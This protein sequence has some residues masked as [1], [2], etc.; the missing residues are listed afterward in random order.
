MTITLKMHRAT[1][2]L[3]KITIYCSN[4]EAFYQNLAHL[5]S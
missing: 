1:Y 2:A 5:D 4:P 3:S